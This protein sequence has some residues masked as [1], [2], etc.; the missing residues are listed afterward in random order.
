MISYTIILLF[1][2]VLFYLSESLFL[3]KYVKD[4]NLFGNNIYNSDNNIIPNINS[5]VNNNNINNINN[6]INNKDYNDS[7]PYIFFTIKEDEDHNW[8]I[9]N[10]I[11][12]PILNLYTINSKIYLRHH[13]NKYLAKRNCYI[14]KEYIPTTMN[15]TSN[16]NGE[17]E[18]F[19]AKNVY[20]LI[21]H[22]SFCY[23][24]LSV[25]GL[26]KSGTSAAYT[27][28]KNYKHK[29]IIGG[30]RKENCAYFHR[31][32]NPNSSISAY[33]QSFPRTI[34]DDQIVINGCILY[35]EV[36]QIH[37]ILDRPNTKYLVSYEQIEF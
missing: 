20:K 28:L 37:Y 2:I 12:F 25:L 23:P 11:N 15:I 18:K 9:L 31:F 14:L 16:S 24:E 27:F 21:Q 8:W 29:T 32:L 36:K 17:N 19:K 34:T 6:I 22:F 7:D 5:N 26:P 4:L 33:F 35:D 3:S 10:S 13:I 1:F 30:Q